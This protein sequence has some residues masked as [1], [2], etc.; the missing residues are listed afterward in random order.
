MNYDPTMLMSHQDAVQKIKD[1]NSKLEE[2]ENGAERTRLYY[3]IMLKG[4]WLT[5]PVY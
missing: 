5:G 3:E 4:L 2:T 1:L